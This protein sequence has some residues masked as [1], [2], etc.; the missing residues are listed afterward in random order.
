MSCA[1]LCVL[2]SPAGAAHGQ[3]VA[4]VDEQVNVIDYPIA[5]WLSVYNNSATYLVDGG[6]IDFSAMMY[7]F[8]W[9]EMSGGAITYD[10]TA[11]TASEVYLFGG[12]VGRILRAQTSASIDWS[13]GTV[14]SA[15]VAA[16]NA[17][18]RIYGSGFTV[19]LAPVP[20]G[21]LAAAEGTLRGTLNDGT[22]ITIPFYHAGAL[23]GGAAVTGTIELVSGDPVQ[24]PPPD[25]SGD[26]VLLN[27]GA[28][29]DVDDDRF[30]PK[31]LGLRLRSPV[32]PTT[33]N[34]LPGAVM[35][36]SIVTSEDSV[37][38]ISG[39]DIGFR[40]H[41]CCPAHSRTATS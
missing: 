26:V 4:L 36:Y 24:S 19:D 34:V 31:P 38:D 22:A 14:G 37:L 28:V 7:Q 35:G 15:V 23:F 20:Y 1:L 8:A 3:S 13:G 17:V 9:L 16:E 21:A 39:G 12:S 32:S 27:D 10:L 25:F 6:Q 29:H 18:I 40:Q 2:V 11:Y 41:V 33:L 30:D 5:G